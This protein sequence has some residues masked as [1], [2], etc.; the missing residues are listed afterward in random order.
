[1]KLISSAE[2]D[3]K[4][5][6]EKIKEVCPEKLLANV[7]KITNEQKVYRFVRIGSEEKDRYPYFIGNPRLFR[8]R[9][10]NKRTACVMCGLSV[11]LSKEDTEYIIQEKFPK[12]EFLILEG[13]FKTDKGNLY[14]TGKDRRRH[15]TF[16][17]CEDFEHDKFFTPISYLPTGI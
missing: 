7:P 1:M 17:P 3:I 14:R 2:E 6:I 12:G 8:Q 10:K 16:F 11:F 15:C 4:I 9:I 13:Y 5:E